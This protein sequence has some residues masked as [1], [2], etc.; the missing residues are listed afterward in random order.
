MGNG[1]I[2]EDMPIDENTKKE[3]MFYDHAFN[4]YLSDIISVNRS[5]PDRRDDWCKRPTSYFSTMDRLPNTSIIIC[6]HNEAWSSLLRT[7]YS[8]LNR[9]PAHLV[10]EILLVD[11]ASTMEHL[12]QNLDTLVGR[13]QKLRLLR[14]PF[15]HGLVRTRMAGIRAADAEVLTFLDSHV[16]ATDG[17]LEPLLDRVARN[18]RTVACP[19]IEAINEKTLQYKFISQVS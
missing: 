11:D 2:L 12:K 18:H 8:V 17:W 1:V 5:L 14:L 4:Q 9:S 7:I 16:E 3:L 6:F 10:H 13:T 15:R 19:V